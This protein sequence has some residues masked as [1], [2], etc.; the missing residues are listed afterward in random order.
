V[1]GGGHRDHKRKDDGSMMDRIFAAISMLGVTAFL[2]VVMWF[3]R[4][5]DLIIVTVLVIAIGV[6]YIW[7]DVAAGGQGA[8]A[9]RLDKKDR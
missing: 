1:S 9:E 6:I 8:I 2:G 4:E 5:P 7:R 3:V